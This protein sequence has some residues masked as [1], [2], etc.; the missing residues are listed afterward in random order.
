MYIMHGGAQPALPF[1]NL[2]GAG[3]GDMPPLSAPSITL[4]QEAA[5]K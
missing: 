5:T 1:L 3:G 2:N 4:P